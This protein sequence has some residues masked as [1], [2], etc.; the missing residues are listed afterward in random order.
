[1]RA[2]KEFRREDKSFWFFI[3]FISE[4]L[5]YSRKGI[6]LT[7]TVEQIEKLCEKENIEV[8]PDRINKAVLYCNMRA[9]LLNNTIEKNLMDVDEAK[10]I[11]EEMR[12]SGKYK[13]KLI[14]NKQRK[15]IKKVNY[16]TAI[17]TMIAEEML[18]GDEEFNPD[19]RGLVYLLNNRKIIGASSRR[20]DGAYPSIYNSKIV[21]E[22]K[23]YYY[24]KSFG[25]RVADAVYEAELDGYEFNEIYDR[26]GQQVYHVMFIDSHYTFW[27]QGKSYLCRF[28]DTLNMGL[29]DELIVGKEVLTRWREVLT[30]FDEK[31]NECKNKCI[32][33]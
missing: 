5:G 33:I 9:D 6:V 27:G 1:M 4:K 21:W 13:C 7:Y 19:P 17:I 8:S 22:I 12:N 26:T 23:E 24:S 31:D 29:I 2:F 15:E 20:F 28:I 14:M 25:S 11:F 3:R 30:E 18:G 16:F 32:I 10:Q